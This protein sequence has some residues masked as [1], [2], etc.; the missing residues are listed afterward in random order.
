[1]TDPIGPIRA[2]LAGRYEIE[3][4]IGEGAFATVFLARDLRH[5]RL[6]AIKVLNADPTSQESELRFLSEIRLLAKLQHPNIVPLI[7]SGHAGATLYY[8]MPYVTGESLRER[9]HREKQLPLE[10]AIAIARE[11]ADAL[12]YAHEQGIIHRDI[13]PENILLSAG[14]PM[15][16]DFGVARAIDLAHVRQLTRKGFVTPGTPAY[17]SPEQLIGDRPIDQRSDIYS[18]GCVL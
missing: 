7:D 4:E 5:E 16:A 18:L 13:K 11:A 1:M 17:M 12:A 10:A 2:A 14:H 6:V 8:V 9:I 3:R 15:I